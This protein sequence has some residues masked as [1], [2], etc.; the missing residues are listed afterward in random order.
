MSYLGPHANVARSVQYLEENL[1]AL[2][3]RLSQEDI[4]AIRKLA[5]D[6]H[7]SLPTRY[8]P[9]GMALVLADTPPLEK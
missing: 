5:E 8:A 3:L 1:G 2:N 9:A 4:D 7:K 6:A